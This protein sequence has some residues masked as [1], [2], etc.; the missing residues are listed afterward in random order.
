M[1]PHFYFMN[2]NRR[3]TN[4]LEGF[5]QKE[6]RGVCHRSLVVSK[7]GLGGHHQGECKRQTKVAALHSFNGT[8]SSNVQQYKSQYQQMETKLD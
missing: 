3:I 6:G 5:L 1:L 2:C 8:G 4:R 7:G